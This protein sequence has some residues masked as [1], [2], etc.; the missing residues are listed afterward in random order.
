MIIQS[1]PAV[2]KGGAIFGT[3]EV[4]IDSRKYSSHENDLVF[5]LQVQYFTIPTD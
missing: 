2:W 5:L 4:C 1:Q 3:M